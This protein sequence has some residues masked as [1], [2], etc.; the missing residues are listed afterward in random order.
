MAVDFKYADGKTLQHE[1]YSVSFPKEIMQ[2]ALSTVVEKSKDLPMN[3][4]YVEQGVEV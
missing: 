1:R 3:C 4:R 2:S